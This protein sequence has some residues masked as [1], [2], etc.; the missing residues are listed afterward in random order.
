[1]QCYHWPRWRVLQISASH[2]CRSLPQ[3][4]TAPLCR[5]ASSTSASPP[6]RNPRWLSDVQTRL[7]KCIQF[8]LRTDAEV[9]TCRRIS[10]VLGNSWK[11]LVAGAEGFCVEP[12]HKSLPD[13][14]WPHQVL[15]GEMDPMNH[16][17]NARY[18]RYAETS[19]IW[20]FRRLTGLVPAEHKDAWENILRPT[21]IGL[22]LKTIKVDFLL[23]IEYPDKLSL[24]HS[25]G[26]YGGGDPPSEINFRCWILSHHH[27]RVAA[28]VE[29]NVP[30]YDYAKGKK[31][32]MPSWLESILAQTRKHDQDSR[33][34]WTSVRENVEGWLK[35]L[36]DST[37][38]SGK[39]ELVG[40]SS[41][42]THAGSAT[43]KVADVMSKDH[44]QSLEQGKPAVADTKARDEKER[45]PRLWTEKSKPTWGVKG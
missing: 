29:E 25:L 42:L 27:Q 2:F 33:E 15:W 31:A 41:P 9:E 12:A 23:P 7:G 3:R 14:I 11:G 8:G 18:L 19:R 44:A 22:I 17:N 20:Y 1:M 4:Q 38:N 28:R 43:P 6:P 40:G 39:E 32:S 10:Q 35:G 37:V 21:G 45:Q 36:E 24:I 16:V 13:P 26:E 30:F 34:Y 5:Y